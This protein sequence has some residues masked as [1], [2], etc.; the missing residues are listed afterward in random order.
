MDDPSE[1][2]YDDPCEDRMTILLLPP[3][4]PERSTARRV[5]SCRAAHKPHRRNKSK[6]PRAC[7][8]ARGHFH[9]RP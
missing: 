8:K 5:A 6:N 3:W 1:M 9:A 4:R 2:I 7:C